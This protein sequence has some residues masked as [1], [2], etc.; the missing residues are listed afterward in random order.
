MQKLDFNRAWTVQKEGDSVIRQTVLPDDA[1]LRETRSP[2]SKSGSGGAFFAG[3]KYIYRKDW[4]VPESLEKK[5]LVLEFEGIYQNSEV[6][7]NGKRIGGRPYGYSNFFIDVTGMVLPGKNNLTVI[8]DNSKIPNTRWYSGSGIYREVRLYVGAVEHFDPDGLAVQIAGANKV[9][10]RVSGDFDAACSVNLTIEDQQGAVVSAA[11]GMDVIM[12]IPDAQSWDAEHPYLYTCRAQL[13]KNDEIIDESAARF[14]I[15]TLS[16]GKEGLLVN[17]KATLLRGACIHHDNG[18]LGACDFADAEYRRVR[19]LKE[20]G[21]NAIRSAHNPVSKAMLDACDELGVYVMDE[22]FDMWLIHKNPYD[23]AGDVFREW[24]QRDVSAM[25]TKD[26]NHPSVLLYSVGNEISELGREDGQAAAK[27]LVALCHKL[28]SSRPVTAGINLALAQMAAM[29]KKSKPFSTDE[30]KIKDDTAGAPTSE[31]FNKLMNYLGSRMDKAASTGGANKIV[32]TVADIFDIPGYNYATSR[33][34]LDG[35]ERPWQ[36]TVG[37]ETFTHMLY[38]NWQ[39]VK[40]I[41]TLIGDFMWTGWDYLGESAIGTIRYMDRKTQK[42]VDSGLI[43][44]SGAGVIDICGK[45]RPETGWNKL[46]WELEYKPVIGVSP[47]THANQFK[48]KRMWRRA[49]TIASWSW[50]GCED[51]R[52]DVTVY[53]AAPIV[54]LFCNG[55]SLGKRKTEEYTAVFSKIPYQAGTLE[56]VSLSADGKEQARTSLISAAGITKIQL[57]PETMT[58]RANGQNLCFLNIDLVGENGITKS[59]ADQ[60][61]TVRVSGPAQLQGFGSARPNMAEGFVGSTHTTYYGK[62]LAVIRA[63]YEPGEAVV[64]VSGKDLET[65]TIKLSILSAGGENS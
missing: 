26:F 6:F 51:A 33:Y 43:I 50:E 1:M 29:S 44:S 55:K 10:V 40:S 2:T 54:E 35:R 64:T 11:K 9:R 17:G 28:D 13:L 3:G 23:Y 5:T 36:S 8:A 37:S 22:A 39:H 16:W 57:V 19:I 27:E 14:G 21:F 41:P 60:A 7:L 46:I 20:S 31:F 32:K 30:G 62:A 56:A 61:L 58:L 63:G 59:S 12:E 15:R 45:Q 52:A 42:D 53:S 49:D 48:S 24:W 34:E 65:Q 4:E 18:V 38:K 47:Y 25:I